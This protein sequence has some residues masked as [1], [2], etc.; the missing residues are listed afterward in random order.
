MSQQLAVELARNALVTMALLA[1]PMLVVALVVGLLVSV[2]QSLTQ[3][4]EQ[5]LSF[6]PKLLAVGGVFLVT[7]PWMLTM[8]R[9]YTVELYRSLPML[10][11]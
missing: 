9:E 10:A 5:T 6:L 8:M 4:Q 1:A 7:L 2:F 11:R 3:I